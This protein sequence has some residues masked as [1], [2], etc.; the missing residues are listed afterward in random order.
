MTTYTITTIT[1]LKRA[2]LLANTG[3]GDLISEDQCAKT[4]SGFVLNDRGDYQGEID[5]QEVIFYPDEVAKAR[6][7]SHD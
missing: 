3:S 1:R 2:N 7:E 4:F 6:K 5:G